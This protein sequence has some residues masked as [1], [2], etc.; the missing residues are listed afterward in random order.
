M[1]VHKILPLIVFVFIS[2]FT[3]FSSIANNHQ[4]HTVISTA[5][6]YQTNETMNINLTPVSENTFTFSYLGVDGEQVN[7]QIS[8]PAT[9]N[10]KYPVMIGI[11]AMGRSFVRWW[12]ASHNGKPTVTH[13][14]KLTE[15]ADEKGYVVIAIDARNHGSRKIKGKEL[16]VVMT[17]L[18]QGKPALYEAMI[19]DTVIDHRLLLDWIAAQKNFDQNNIRVAGYS[20][21]AQVSLLLASV[22]DRIKNVLAI[23]PPYVEQNLPHIS[24]VNMVPLLTKTPVLLVTSNKDQ[25]STEDQNQQLFNAIPS[26]N[27]VRM[28]F[29]SDHLL[30]PN[31]VNSLAFWF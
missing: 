22:D 5:F 21:G 7:G 1:Y 9:K 26:E 25:Y 27:K 8:Y 6:D 2:A 12:D 15:F 20:M 14:N 11:H 3:S 28:V 19:K 29:N 16:G 4:D 18:K 23:V 10:E 30:P 24:P 31:Y 13:V 17:Q